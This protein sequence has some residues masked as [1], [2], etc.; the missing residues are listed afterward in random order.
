MSARILRLTERFNLAVRRHGATSGTPAGR[1]LASLLVT[2]QSGDLPGPDTEAMMPPVARY[3]FRRL[4]GF[5]LWLFY[6]FDDS[7][8]TAISLT[9]NPPIPLNG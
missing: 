7:Q 4:S 9:T 6:S 5:N 8:L 3:Y 1:A 2:M